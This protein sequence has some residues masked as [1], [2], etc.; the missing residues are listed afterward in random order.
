MPE[1]CHV[2]IHV[3]ANTN[4][5]PDFRV[6]F[7]FRFENRQEPEPELRSGILARPLFRFRIPPLP[8]R[9]AR[10]FETTAEAHRTATVWIFHMIYV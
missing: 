9:M 3:I 7:I 4:R 2:G 10:K 1:R 5:D 6:E 8:L